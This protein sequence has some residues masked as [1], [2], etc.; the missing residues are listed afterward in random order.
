MKAF[1]E[2]PQT[3]SDYS[4]QVTLINWS[5]NLVATLILA[6]NNNLYG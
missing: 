1:K 2:I 4:S 3:E 6:S 5:I